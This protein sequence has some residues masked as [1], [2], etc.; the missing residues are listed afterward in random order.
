MLISQCHFDR[1]PFELLGPLQGPLKQTAFMKPMGPLKSTGRGVIVPPA[2][3]LLAALYRMS[4]RRQS[5]RCL[6]NLRFSK[7]IIFAY[8]HNLLV[9]NSSC[10]LVS[11]RWK[12]ELTI[13]AFKNLVDSELDVGKTRGNASIQRN[14]A[15][16][17][18]RIFFSGRHQQFGQKKMANSNEE[19]FL[20]FCQRFFCFSTLL[21][22]FLDRIRPVTAVESSMQ[23]FTVNECLVAQSAREPNL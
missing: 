22:L 19:T 18:M 13:V 12:I 9:V 20:T 14:K 23:Y 1:P 7:K 6:E 16:W 21:K 5:P 15:S 11:S 10:P 4:I 2:P 3:P 8:E 17:L